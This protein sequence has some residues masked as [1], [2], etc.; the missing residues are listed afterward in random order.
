VDP[1]VR[2]RISNPADQGRD[3]LTIEGPRPKR[4]PRQ[5]GV[6]ASVEVGIVAGDRL[7]GRQ[8]LGHLQL[9]AEGPGGS[10]PD[11]ARRVVAQRRDLGRAP[12]RPLLPMSVISENSASVGWDGLDRTAPPRERARR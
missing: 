3:H 8:V 11:R 2:R 7:D 6:L 12:P 1:G 9:K 5:D 4:A 10:T